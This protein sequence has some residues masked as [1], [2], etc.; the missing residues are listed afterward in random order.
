ML[1]KYN[2]SEHFFQ[3][4]KKFTTLSAAA[5]FTYAIRLAISIRRAALGTD[6]GNEVFNRLTAASAPESVLKG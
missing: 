4:L 2:T 5:A 1:D 6:A 3:E